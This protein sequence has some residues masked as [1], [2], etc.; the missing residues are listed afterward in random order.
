M[1]PGASPSALLEGAASYVEKHKVFQLFEGLL[2]DLIIKRPEDPIDHLIKALKR[3]EVPR[4]IIFGPPGAQARLLCEQVSAKLNLVHVIAGDVYRD[5]AKAGS[6]LGKEAKALVDGNQEVPSEML[7]KLLHEKLYSSDCTARGWVLE[8]FPSGATQ[9]RA[10]LAAG[11]LPKTVIQL[12]LSDEEVVRRLTGRRV[13]PEANQVYHVTDSPAPDGIAGRL[14]QRPEDTEARV[15]E[16][17]S[18][19]RDAMGGAAPLFNKVLKDIDI[20]G[21]SEAAVL[22][23]VLPYISTEVPTKAPRGCP[24][25]L[26]LGGPGSGK[27]ALAAAMAE[28]FGAKLVSALELMQAAVLSGSPLGRHAKPY[29]DKGIPEEV[30]DEVLMPLV[31]Q[32]L[33]SEDIR[34]VGFVMVGVPQISSQAAALKKMGVWFRHVVYL[35]ISPEDAKRAVCDT[36]YDP[37]DGAVY[38]PEGAWPEDL[39]VVARLVAHPHQSPAAFNKALKRWEAVEPKLI[40]AISADCEI[41]PEDAT[42]SHAELLERLTPCFLTL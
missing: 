2:E 27:E 8:G 18:L 39:E 3:P 6:A 16:R 20:E 36:R 5:L 31:A 1:A 7:V 12:S 9:T 29:L 26:L 41:T 17:L 42:A 11:L 24:R 37:V 22:E 28:R 25:V 33:D 4:V 15:E 13:D 38:H 19:Y 23:E 32:R 14:V 30:P 34:K 10:M 35:Q 21:K 40:N